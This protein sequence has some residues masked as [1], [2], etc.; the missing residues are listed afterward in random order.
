[1]KIHLIDVAPRP[2]KK[3][4]FQTLTLPRVAG[5]TPEDCEVFIT[6]GRV[7]DIDITQPADLVGLTFSCNNSTIAYDL[8]ARAKARGAKVVAGGTHATAMPEEALQHVDAVL[9]GEAEGGAWERL[10]E[11]FDRGELGGVYRNGQTPCIA[12]LRP[13]RLDLLRHPE[14]Y[15][16]F[17]PIEATRGCTHNCSF[18]FNSTIHG[19]G[20][21]T[22]PVE[23]VV[24]DARQATSRNLMFMDDNLC[25]KRGY[26]KE[27]F[28]GLAPLKKRLF[29]QTHLL[30]AEDQELLELAREAGAQFAFVGIESFE[31]ASLQSVDKGWNKIER[32]KTWVDR[33]HAHG[34]FVSAGLILGLDSDGPDIFDKTIYYLR[35]IGVDNAAVNMLIPYPG[36]AFHAEMARQGRI[37]TEDVR[38]YTG[39]DL[40]VK[41]KNMTVEEL[42]A[43]YDKVLQDFYGLGRFAGTMVKSRLWQ[44]APVYAMAWWREPRRRTYR[45]LGRR[46]N[47]RGG[48]A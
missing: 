35:Q 48:D 19:L 36:T 34:I 1:M 46:L 26:A 29:F 33:F 21:R 7:E 44:R 37:L 43:G 47:R 27:L 9:V 3:Q 16:D 13:P 12:R 32:Y 24:E 2:G 45:S 15:L 42:A 38:K 4:S 39:F 28:R 20:F 41:P 17:H 25:G 6:D 18:C 5:C 8:A 14:R 10:L 30:M 22:R 31:A 11:D 40:V 23:D